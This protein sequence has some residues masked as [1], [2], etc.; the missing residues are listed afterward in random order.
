MPR[1]VPP[2]IAAGALGANAQPV[3]GIGD[4]VRARPWEGG[5]RAALVAAFADLEIQRWH[6]VR[7]DSTLEADEWIAA[8]HKGWRS[9]TVASW[10]IV[11]DGPNTVLGRISLYFKD[12]CNGIGETTYWVVPEGR[13]RGLAS[14][15]V[16]AVC[17]WA[18]DEAGLHRIELAHSV[19][20]PASC[21]VAA[22]AGFGEEGVRMSALR[23]QD[24]WHDMH[25][26]SRVIHTGP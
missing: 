9:E 18:F 24:G 12:L 22:K 19:H 15:A 11:G 23:H 21:R 10:A 4:G 3:L 14:M 25:A 17:S 2:V 16:D 8:T 6:L 20:N 1:L 7:L 26:H 13:G 5:D